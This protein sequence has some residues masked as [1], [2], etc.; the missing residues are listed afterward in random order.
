MPKSAVGMNLISNRWT[1]LVDW[2]GGLDRWTG[3]H[4]FSSGASTCISAAI[5][6]VSIEHANEKFSITS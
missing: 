2:I 3:L 6:F 5:M 4:N 1:G